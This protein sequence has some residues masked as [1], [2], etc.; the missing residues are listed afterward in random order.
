MQ[1]LQQAPELIEP[2]GP[3]TGASRNAN[4]LVEVL[5][6]RLHE[7]S[8]LTEVL[9]RR[10][11]F[12]ELPEQGLEEFLS[13]GQLVELLSS[14]GPLGAELLEPEGFHPLRRAVFSGPR[15]LRRPLGR[16]LAELQPLAAEVPVQLRC[17]LTFQA[18]A[19]HGTTTILL[20]EPRLVVGK[21]PA[22]KL[23]PQLGTMPG[24]GALRAFCAARA[25]AR[26]AQDAAVEATEVSAPESGTESGASAPAR[27]M[28]EGH[29]SARHEVWLQ[30]LAR[31]HEAL[32]R[33]LGFSSLDPGSCWDGQMF[34][35]AACCS[36]GEHQDSCWHGGFSEERCC[37]PLR[38]PELL[39]EEALQLA[40][41]Q[42]A[43]H[44]ASP[45]RAAPAVAAWL[46]QPNGR[47]AKA[48]SGLAAEA[49]EASA[50]C[51]EPPE[52]QEPAAAEQQGEQWL[53]G[54][55]GRGKACS[56][57]LEP[58]LRP[59]AVERELDAN[60]LEALSLAAL[61]RRAAEP[62]LAPELAAKAKSEAQVR[63]LQRLESVLKKLQS[64]QQGRETRTATGPERC[65][66]SW[67]AGGELAK[68]QRLRVRQEGS[69][70]LWQEV[71]LLDL[72]RLVRKEGVQQLHLQA[73]VSR[74]A[75]GAGTSQ[76]LY[77]DLSKGWEVQVLE[78]PAGCKVNSCSEDEPEKLRWPDCIGHAQTIRGVA[79]AGVFV[80]LAAFGITD[81][82][83]RDDCG[84]TDHFASGSPATCARTC[85]SIRACRWWSFWTSRTGGT[86]WLRR[87][88]Q[89]RDTMVESMT[90]SSECVPPATAPARQT[91]AEPTL[92]QLAAGSMLG[93]SAPA[94]QW[95]LPKVL[96]EFGHLTPS[97]IQLRD[98]SPLRSSALRF[99]RRA[100]EARPA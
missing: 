53:P 42:L 56:I 19:S 97:Q 84:Y 81:G 22:A 24:L 11:S 88:D 4:D 38:A 49:L 98:S 58:E 62:A 60:G 37:Q 45:A 46:R 14:D 25:A 3:P 7:R 55:S 94:F 64:K 9:L 93:P 92:F 35:F 83:F 18:H 87:H 30:R 12:E 44:C 85:A 63:T 61:R 41:A 78:L 71:V 23:T 77:R 47:G 10:I 5:G 40:L 69:D 50:G 80:N 76:V 51:V 1:A 43:G 13:P 33:A 28:I 73:V 68:G 21:E 34:T 95:D 70:E 86:C 16:A 75:T 72:L 31:S 48:L 91:S 32:L 96:E 59:G 20:S 15:G 100:K 52:L 17:E 82:C 99:A 66:G 65:C 74:D 36:V 27:L 2:V 8:G 57:F 39:S 54:P 29:S 89:Q 79:G 67:R 6:V 90:A 26:L